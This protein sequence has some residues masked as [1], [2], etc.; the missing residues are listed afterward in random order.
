MRDAGA[1]HFIDAARLQE[2]PQQFGSRAIPIGLA[3]TPDGR[4]AAS[5]F[6]PKLWQNCLATSPNGRM[7][8]LTYDEGVVVSDMATMQP[9]ATLTGFLLSVHS[10]AFSPDG[11]LLAAGG[12]GK[13]A[14]KL[15]DI[16]TWQEVLT[17]SGKGPVY[18]LKFSP[19]GRCLLG[20]NLSGRAFLW[21]APT[22]AGIASAEAAENQRQQQGNGR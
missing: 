1:F 13:E 11:R 9:V 14:V 3:T 15:W 18:G 12:E 16:K 4:I 20:V 22:L 10:V 21:S 19:D 8:A 2:A 6:T 7:A 5:G 17:L